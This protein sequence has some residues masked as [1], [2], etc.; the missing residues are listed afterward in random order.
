MKKNHSF[1]FN[2]DTW[3]NDFCMNFLSNIIRFS[4]DLINKKCRNSGSVFKYSA[5]EEE[6]RK[7]F[8]I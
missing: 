6:P 7:L 1:F 2:K 3:D 5:A 4:S 8:S